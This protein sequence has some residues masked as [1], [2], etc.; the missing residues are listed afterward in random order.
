MI[1]LSADGAVSATDLAGGP[2]LTGR[3]LDI[4]CHESPAGAATKFI[5]R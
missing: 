2:R 1:C 5:L 4:G 3:Y